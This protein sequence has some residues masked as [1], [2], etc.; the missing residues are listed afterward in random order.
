MEP[1]VLKHTN[2][3][4]EE[5]NA[6]PSSCQVFE[7]IA[8][9]TVST[10]NNFENFGARNKQRE[11][12][13]C[14]WNIEGLTDVKLEE[15]NCYMRRHGI[16][17]C[18]LQETR[19][20]DSA[21]YTTESGNLLIM[22][23]ST[24]AEASHAG[25]GFII[26]K[27]TKHHVKKFCQ[28]S[29]RL[30]SVT[31]KVRGGSFSICNVYAPHNLKDSSLKEAFYD[32][33]NKHWQRLRGQGGRCIFGDMNARLGEARPGEEDVLGEFC[34]GREAIFKVD[35]PNRDLLMEFCYSNTLVVANT[36]SNHPV[37]QRVTYRELDVKPMDDVTPEKFSMLDLLVIPADSLHDVISVCSD[38][39]ATLS[40]QHF[41]VIAALRTCV[42]YRQKQTKAKAM[43]W[44]VLG[45]NKVQKELVDKSNKHG[46]PL[47]ENLDA[48]W[49]SMC[50]Q[51]L[52]VAEELLPMKKPKANK[53][54]ISESTLELIE[55]KRQARTSNSWT[56]EREL[57]KKIKREAKNDRA[58]WL[59]DLSSHGDWK[60]LRFLRKGIAHQQG[61]LKNISGDIVPSDERAD[62]LAE[63]FET[64]QWKIRDT[65][66]NDQQ[67]P[68]LRPTLPISVQAFTESE[69]RRAI[70]KM[71]SGKSCKAGDLPVEYFKALASG[72]GLSGVLELCNACLA[73]KK[74]PTE[75]S[76]ADVA[77][78]FKKGDPSLC[79]NYRPISLQTVCNKI[80]MSMI[81][82]RLLDGGVEEHIWPSQF[83][84]RR[85]YSTED[86]IYIARRRVELAKAQRHGQ[87][88]LLALDWAKAFDSIN[89]DSLVDAL[90]RFGVPADL[91]DFI[92]ILLNERNFRV[93]DC[94]TTSQARPQR[95][96]ISQGCTL[97]PLLFIMVMSVLL[98]DAVSMLSPEA[99]EAYL[100]GDLSD[101][102]Y[103]DDTLLIGVS[104]KHLSE[105]LNAVKLAGDLYGMQLHMG[106]LQ[107]LPI[108]CNPVVGLPGEAPLQPK[109]RMDYLGSTLSDDVHDAH[110][111]V[112]R[113]ALAKADFIALNNVWHRSSLTWKGK[114]RIFESLVESKLLYSLNSICL[115]QAQEKKLDGFQA[116]CLRAIIGVKPSY[117]S[118]VSNKEVL[119]KCCHKKAT[120]LLKIRQLKLLEKIKESRE[121]HPLRVV[122]FS[123]GSF[124]RPATDE[125]VRRVGRPHKEW[126]KSLL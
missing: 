119:E 52:K 71:K 96:G 125:Y 102:V 2:D 8:S 91:L 9:E 16:D 109:R 90:R 34:F 84:F 98:D 21:Y 27:D 66:L 30:A 72:N 4:A 58:R 56:R 3:V 25:V 24:E 42:D 99:S 13:V 55:L 123:R 97:S 86:A 63:Y 48:A 26:A 106:K 40:S 43:D 18:C 59:M 103:A 73:Q 112:R 15:V 47:I 38:R 76:S 14:T 120:E 78:I 23:G 85:A 37:E 105:Y 118:R 11:L 31:L 53:P 32:E 81:K 67:R 93:Q 77:A 46:K 111:L 61:R 1:T 54:W 44:S 94:G 50:Q 114:L 82:Q 107:L 28:I 108:Q 62:T 10:A 45:D 87:V 51:G 88:S 5:F 12:R 113:I 49:R 35:L 75:W 41:P 7:K 101:I 100:R 57:N 104:D 89:V 36:H 33:L 116:R 39:F 70:K 60:A 121:G 69:L 65:T 19:A 95:S 68:C 17:V 117:I 74:V 92:K 64:V 122:T 22:S 20:K 110:E 124:L 126:L 83:G 115:T 80:L 79:E 29:S 6:C